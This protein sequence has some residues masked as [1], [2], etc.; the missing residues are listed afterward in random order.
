MGSGSKVQ[1]DRV[2]DTSG[3]LADD[4]ASA[5]LVGGAIGHVIEK[6]RILEQQIAD[7]KGD[8]SLFGCFLREDSYDR[9]DIVI[10]APWFK[11][12]DVD[13]IEFFSE[14]IKSA[15]G[16]S[17]LLIISRIVPLRE[18]NRFLTEVNEMVKVRHG[19]RSITEVDLAG[20]QVSR[21][22]IITSFPAAAHNRFE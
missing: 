4:S 13:P 17:G 3:R 22:F 12:L 16:R 19:L 20:V 15:V 18:N 10:A 5:D 9:W 11:K 21:A 8:F 1:A 7:E 6:L 14:R 2:S